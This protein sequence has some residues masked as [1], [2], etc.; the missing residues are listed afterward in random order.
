MDIAVGR[1]YVRTALH[2]ALEGLVS[3]TIFLG[4][5]ITVTKVWHDTVFFKKPIKG[6]QKIVDGVSLVEEFI[7]GFKPLIQMEENE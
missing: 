6:S 5:V 3:N 4:Q 2:E 1:K 7:D